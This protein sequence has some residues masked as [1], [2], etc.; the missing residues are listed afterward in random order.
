VLQCVAVYV[1]H[2]LKCAAVY[3]SMLQCV[4]V[5]TRR[6]LQCVAVC[7]SVLQ[8]IFV[9][10]VLRVH[11][12][13]SK[14]ILKVL[15]KSIFTVCCQCIRVMCSLQ[16]TEANIQECK[17]IFVVCAN[18]CLPCVCVCH[19]EPNNSFTVTHSHAHLSNKK[20][21]ECVRVA[22]VE[23]A[24][25]CVPFQTHLTL[26]SRYAHFTVT[27]TSAARKKASVRAN[28][29]HLETFRVLLLFYYHFTLA[30]LSL[31][32]HFTLTLLSFYSHVYL[33]NQK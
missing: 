24:C 30:V 22:C 10:R 25:E 28:V 19:F 8:C 27:R 15:L 5:Y 18:V 21:G 20:E 3:C 9:M 31:Y 13:H 6:V 23:S 33:S 2:V 16:H 29:H 26:L 12:Q 4:A 7:C 32:S 14:S 1:C 17:C 11:S